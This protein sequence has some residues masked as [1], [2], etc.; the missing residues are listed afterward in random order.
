MNRKI[1]I[2]ALA[3]FVLGLFYGV[4]TNAQVITPPG[5]DEEPGNKEV[6]L[7]WGMPTKTEA[8]T[9]LKLSDIKE[10]Q[11]HYLV[12][13][14]M[15]VVTVSKAATSKTIKDLSPGLYEFVIYTVDSAGEI[16]KA[17]NIAKILL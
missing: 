1:S 8:G 5:C 13:A 10:Y 2:I 3:A 7:R 17:S 16:S 4:S 6:T 14:K 15:K 9:A 11:V 12:G